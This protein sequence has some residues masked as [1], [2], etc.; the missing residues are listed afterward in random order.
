MASITQWDNGRWR[1]RVRR[2][3]GRHAFKTFPTK[4]EAAA[5]AASEER[6]IHQRQQ[7]DFRTAERLLFRDLLERYEREKAAKLKS[8]AILHYH[9]ARLHEDFGHL[10]FAALTPEALTAWRD[11]RLRAVAPATVRRELQT[12]GGVITWARKDLL[13]ALPENPVAAIRLPPPSKARDRRLE[14]DEEARLLEALE[15]HAAP[16]AG[17]KRAGNYRVGTRN[18][19]IKP[20]VLVA[21]ETAMRL[22]E[23]VSLR[24]EH[25]DLSRATAHLPDTK[26]GDARTVPL[27]RRAV[28]I[29]NGLPRDPDEPRVFP[30]AANAVKLAWNRVMARAGI[31]NLHFHD[32]RHEATSRLSTKLPNLVELGSV[33]GHKD[34]RML[35]RY[36]HPRAEDLAKKLG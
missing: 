2:K 1:A 34:L 27:S 4:A 19:W 31:P 7:R 3:D 29:L 32:L 36:Y 9:L 21:L 8:A 23:L 17:V 25:V 5:W 12:L 20:L 33:T 15:D 30:V 11:E 14:D 10:R 16:T 35:Q 6:N 28:A 18:P 13:I 24:W 26:N 22:G